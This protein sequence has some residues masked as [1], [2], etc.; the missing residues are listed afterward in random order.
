[1]LSVGLSLDKDVSPKKCLDFY[2]SRFDFLYSTIGIQNA[3]KFYYQKDL[4][5]LSDDE[6]FELSV[7]TLNPAFYNKIRR[8]D[9]LKE[10]VEKV[11]MNKMQK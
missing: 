1:M 3:S 8:P 9:I 4:E 11:K 6:M 10:K 5:Q 7:M 2:L